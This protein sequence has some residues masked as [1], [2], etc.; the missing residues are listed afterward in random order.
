MT[1]NQEL[2][3]KSAHELA[4]LL[5]SGKVTA[6]TL[7]QAFLDQISALNPVLNAYLYID[8]DGALAEA[9]SVDA[10]REAGNTLPPFAGVPVAIKDNIC[11]RG[12]PTTCGSRMLEG[13]KPPYDATV[14]TRIRQ[15]RLPILGHTNMDEF[16][17]GSS[18]EHSAFGPTRN[19]WDTNRIPGGSGGGSAAAVSAYLAPWAL[20]TDTGGSIRQPSSVTGT[21]GAKPT[22]GKIS[23]YGVVAMASSLDQVGPV[24]RSVADA[25]A[26]QEILSAYDP[27]D[28]TSLPE[29]DL[30][31]HTGVAAAGSASD[32]AGKRFGVVKELITGGYEPG[33]IAVF[34]QIRAQLAA[35]GAQIAEV[36]CPSFEHALA[37]Y[38]LIMPA[39]VSSNLARFDG[40]RYGNRVLPQS[41]PI[42]AETM[43]SATREANFGAEAKRRIILGTHVLSAGYFDAYYGSAQ[44]VRTLV[45]RDFAAAFEQCDVL[46][47][48]T[49]PV[50]AFP[51][52]AKADPM[53]MYINDIATIP[54]NLAGA[55]AMSVPGGLSEGL[56]VGVQVIAPTHQDARMYEYAAMVEAVADPAGARCPAAK[57]E[58]AE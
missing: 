32:L 7:T 10:D 53:A 29:K 37:A 24:A 57:L 27:F 39:E 23:R 47:S 55:P 44:K 51:F 2:C 25:A 16:A 20:G 13:W 15:A 5:R 56:P 26:L 18:T 40:V 1:T 19:P 46:I 12:I 38:Y 33:V 31:L 49:S 48:P 58:V 50:V 35:R 11:Q 6:V 22:Y 30:D 43:M 21:V 3:R 14:V 52:G 17:M 9:K 41:G 36:S 4:A 45:Q 42:T 54:A 28:S 34:E 8:A